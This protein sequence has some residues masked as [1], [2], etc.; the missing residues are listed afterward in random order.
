MI[1][2]RLRGFFAREALAR[3]TIALYELPME[4]PSVRWRQELPPEPGEGPDH[5]AQAR[6]RQEW[7]VRTALLLVEEQTPLLTHDLQ[8]RVIGRLDEFVDY[9]MTWDKFA[10]QS[11]PREEGGLLLAE[12]ETSILAGSPPEFRSRLHQ[13]VT[14]RSAFTIV[15]TL[16]DGFAADT[17]RTMPPAVQG[18][19]CLWLTYLIRWYQAEGPAGLRGRTSRHPHFFAPGGIP[20]EGDFPRAG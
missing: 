20:D 15:A 6:A 16:L 10:Q 1:A 5:D 8:T 2:N 11:P 19:A 7:L 18:W 12:V 3:T 13:R 17:I 4:Y 14:G 9:R